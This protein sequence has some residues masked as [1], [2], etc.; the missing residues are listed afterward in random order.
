M[1][2]ISKTSSMGLRFSMTLIPVVVLLIGFVVFR[3]K[4][5]LSDEKMNEITTEL[6]NRKGE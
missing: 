4:Y 3:K 6:S 2:P 1:E 5:I